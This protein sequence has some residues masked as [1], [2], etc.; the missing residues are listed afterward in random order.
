MELRDK[1]EK[2][3]TDHEGIFVDLNC[4]MNNIEVL[5]HHT[6]NMMIDLSILLSNVKSCSYVKKHH[7]YKAGT[8]KKAADPSS[9]ARMKSELVRC[10]EV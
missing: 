4:F 7:K 6:D 9:G 2:M 3:R 1:I 10:E 5:K 8:L